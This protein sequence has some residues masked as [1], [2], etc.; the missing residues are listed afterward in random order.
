MNVSTSWAKRRTSRRHGEARLEG[1]GLAVFGRQQRLP[2]QSRGGGRLRS[3]RGRL[4]GRLGEAPLQLRHAA[5]EPRLLEVRNVAGHCDGKLQ[6]ELLEDARPPGRRER[7][8]LSHDERLERLAPVGRRREAVRGGLAEQV[9][10]QLA[11]LPVEGDLVVRERS[12]RDPRSGSRRAPVRSAAG[13]FRAARG[14]CLRDR[15]RRGRRRRRAAREEGPP[16][17]AAAPL[18]GARKSGSRR[19]SHEPTALSSS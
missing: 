17:P 15:L 1:G 11:R 16:A 2:R 10:G 3:R 8:K 7:V 6:P 18:H 4:R 13:R 14:G 9:V 19:A 12:A 5:P